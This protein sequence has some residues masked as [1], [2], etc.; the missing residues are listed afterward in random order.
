MSDIGRILYTAKDAIISNLTAINV[1]GSNISNVSTPG[2]TRIRPLFESVGTRQA[3]SNQEQIGVK[4]ADIQRVYDKFLGSQ[5]VAQDS[6]V[7]SATARKN[8]LTQIEGIVNESRGDGINDAPSLATAHIG[9]A[10]G[11]GTD[12]AIESADVVLMKGQ[13]SRLVSLIKLSKKT[14]WVIKE[15]LFWAFIYNI[16]GIPIAFGALYPFF[17]IRFE[18]IYGALAMMISSVS[19]V[20]NSL[21][22][23]MFKD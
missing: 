15:N 23:R 12:I 14:L 10:M 18:P 4:I 7:G 2:Y 19:V 6:A 22:L 1:T 20:S 11:K 9:V 21:R 8:L 13:L 5:I 17:G 3:S 16:L